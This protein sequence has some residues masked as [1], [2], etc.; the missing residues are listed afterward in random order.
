MTITIKT[1]KL[2]SLFF[3]QARLVFKAVYILLLSFISVLAHSASFESNDHAVIL[4]YHHVSNDTPASTSIS[5]VKFKK[6]IEYL[7]DNNF[8]I[9]PLSKT[10]SY[11]VTNKSLPSKT[12]V[13]TFDDAYKSVYT[14]AFPLL[15]KHKLPFTVFVTTGYIGEEN[16]N[17]MSWDQLREITMS[18]GELGNHSDRHE[19]LVRKKNN[20]TAQ[21]WRLRIRN[22]IIRAQT[23]LK[24]Q[25]GNPI[26]VV[27]YPYGEY[28]TELKK[29]IMDLGYFGLGQHSG[30]AHRSSDFQSIPRYPLSTG[31]DD[32]E[33]FALKVSSLSL[34]VTV[35]SPKNGVLSKEIEIPELKL[36]LHEADYDKNNFACYASGQGKIKLQWLNK[37]QG[38]V[39]VK[40]NSVISPGRT[41]YNCT[42]PSRNKNNVFYWFSFLWMKP[43]ADGSWYIE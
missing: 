23:I 17:F 22:E 4:M 12:V 6:H 10:L 5:P 13:I 8:T 9:W 1:F 25:T 41:K 2:Y 24:E 20:E 28:S 11:L 37:D 34:P 38:L 18:G 35:I 26:R 32:L 3:W 39:N 36:Q 31:F 7:I 16:F 43:L 30:V 27:A 40:A 42:A 33:D 19:H 21:Q 14:K 15:K 29:I